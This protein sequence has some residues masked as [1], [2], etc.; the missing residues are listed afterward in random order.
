MV[1]K[2]SATELLLP[3]EGTVS[4]HEVSTL[5]TVISQPLATV[6]ISVGR[7]V[8]VDI[9]VQIKFLVIFLSC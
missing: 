6:A 8:G 1:G 4:N 9:T 2:D 3:L 5:V 7:W